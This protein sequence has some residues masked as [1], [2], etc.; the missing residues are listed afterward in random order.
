M[1]NVMGEGAAAR[2]QRTVAAIVRTIWLWAGSLLSTDTL[3]DNGPVFKVSC[4]VAALKATRISPWPPGGNRAGQASVTV[5]LQVLGPGASSQRRIPLVANQEGLGKLCGRLDD[6]QLLEGLPDHRPGALAAPGAGQ[7]GGHG[8]G[9]VQRRHR[10]GGRRAGRH[11][12]GCRQS[13]PRESA[14]DHGGGFLGGVAQPP[15]IIRTTVRVSCVRRYDSVR[16]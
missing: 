4:L 3:R 6:A 1:V 2:R 16:I 5:H 7:I 11:G 12:E 8:A 10:D 15:S 9:T 14:K 13:N